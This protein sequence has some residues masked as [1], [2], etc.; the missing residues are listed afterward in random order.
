MLQFSG[1]Q[2]VNRAT[3]AAGNAAPARAGGL[4]YGAYQPVSNAPQCRGD[5]QPDYDILY[6]HVSE[7]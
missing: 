5:D 4:L 1:L 6:G 2:F 7:Y 3:P